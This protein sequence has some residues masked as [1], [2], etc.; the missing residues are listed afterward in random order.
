MWSFYKKYYSFS[1]KKEPSGS[2]IYISRKNKKT[3]KKRR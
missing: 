1:N 3:K 2:A